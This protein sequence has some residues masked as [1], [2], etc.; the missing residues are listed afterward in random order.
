[1]RRK[2]SEII[3]TVKNPDF[4]AKSKKDGESYLYFRRSNGFFLLVAATPERKNSTRF[5][6]KT[7]FYVLNTSK[8]DQIIWQKKIST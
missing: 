7:S 8:G 3:L 5:I 1:M 6:V 4:I 2:V